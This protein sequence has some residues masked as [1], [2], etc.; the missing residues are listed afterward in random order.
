MRLALVVLF[1]VALHVALRPSPSVD[2]ALHSAQS[3]TGAESAAPE[4]A[5]DNAARDSGTQTATPTV[6]GPPA[7]ALPIPPS[8]MTG[9]TPAPGDAGESEEADQAVRSGEA[10]R[11]GE[12]RT[13]QHGPLTQAD[14]ES[15]IQKELTRLAC[16]TGRPERKWGSRSRAALRRFV[17]RAKPKDGNAPSEAL[18]RLMRD[19]PANYCKTCSR[20]GQASCRI[21]GR[22]RRRSESETQPSVKAAAEERLGGERTISEKV[23]SETPTPEASYLPPWMIE[24]GQIAK[25]QDKVRTDVIAHTSPTVSPPPAPRAKRTKRV[26]RQPRPPRFRSAREFNP[27]SLSG[28]PRY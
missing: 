23:I 8:A 13:S 6:Q 24:D 12:Q 28:W 17:S 22:G 4:R 18:L 7:Q 27:P 16:L 2:P 14:I 25:V 21:G 11:P 1:F 9:A 26:V 19:Y 5:Q 3:G 20:P 15:G 10:E